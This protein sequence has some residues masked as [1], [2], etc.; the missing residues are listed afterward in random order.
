MKLTMWRVLVVLK[1]YTK[2]W[3]KIVFFTFPSSEG[4][5]KKTIQITEITFIIIIF[6]GE[7]PPE[8]EVLK[9]AR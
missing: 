3:G 8:P 1:K 7:G 4:K 6:W 5:V 9:V 2:F